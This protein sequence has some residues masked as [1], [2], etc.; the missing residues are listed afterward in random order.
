MIGR[1][2][3]LRRLA[4]RLPG[5]DVVDLLPGTSLPPDARAV[6]ADHDLRGANDAYWTGGEPG[7]QA[8]R[9]DGVP[10]HRFVDTRTRGDHQSYVAD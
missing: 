5:R 6:L 7:S 9:V 1:D 8:G 2:A 3:R 10:R 4:D